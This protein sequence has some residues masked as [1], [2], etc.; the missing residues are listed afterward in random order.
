MFSLESGRQ[1]WAGVMRNHLI[2]LES[3]SG[4]A[5]ASILAEGYKAVIMEPMARHR[6]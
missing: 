3:A 4:A 2:Q 1:V 5:C 6:A